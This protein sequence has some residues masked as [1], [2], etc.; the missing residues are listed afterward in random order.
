MRDMRKKE[1]KVLIIKY[2]NND[3][4]KTASLQNIFKRKKFSI[5]E[6]S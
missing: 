1:I 2:C 4:K 5:R 6:T 3:N